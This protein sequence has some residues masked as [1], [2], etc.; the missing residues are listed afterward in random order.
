MSHNYVIRL[1]GTNGRGRGGDDHHCG[2]L[3]SSLYIA[4]D[5]LC[6][7]CTLI[8]IKEVTQELAVELN[9]GAE[10]WSWGN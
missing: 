4:L 3:I 5:L 2:G 10:P 6:G 8:Y 7:G 9:L 1:S